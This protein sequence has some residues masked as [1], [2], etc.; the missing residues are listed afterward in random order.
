MRLDDV[1]PIQ[2]TTM[3]T[4]SA[5]YY[6]KIVQY[7]GTTTSQYTQ[8]YFYKCDLGL[9]PGSYRWV[10]T[11][12]V[13]ISFKEN[14]II[15]TPSITLSVAGWTNNQQTV[16]TG[17]V[18]ILEDNRNIIDIP[19]EEVQTWADCGVMLFS[20]S[21]YGTDDEM[22][23]N[24]LIFKCDTVPDTALTFKVTSMEVN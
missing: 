17:G 14:A 23:I 20:H 8:G 24:E 13:G 21:A 18:A 2:Y 15:Q 19:Y 1:E 9:R 6:G 4:A 7:I 12:V 10:K 16:G 11:D 3:P 22:Y 5:E